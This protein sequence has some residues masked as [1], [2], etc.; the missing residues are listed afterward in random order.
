[1][2]RIIH[3]HKPLNYIQLNPW[4]FDSSPTQAQHHL[5]ICHL[6]QLPDHRTPRKQLHLLLVKFISYPSLIVYIITSQ[7]E[8]KGC[9][10]GMI[11]RLAEKESHTSSELRKQI[12]VY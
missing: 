3:P 11:R 8:Y 2:L 9:Y 1:M 10:G 7:L 4:Y 12:S 6:S 5:V